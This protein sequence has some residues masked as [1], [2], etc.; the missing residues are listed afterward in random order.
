LKKN[1]V[2]WRALGLTRLFQRNPPGEPQC[3]PPGGDPWST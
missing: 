3:N 1:L 2:R